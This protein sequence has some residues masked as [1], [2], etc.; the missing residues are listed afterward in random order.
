MQDV[1]Q[2]EQSPTGTAAL[3]TSVDEVLFDR[4]GMRV[5]T[6]SVVMHGRRW[7]LEHVCGVTVLFQRPTAR[8]M[9][10]FAV[11]AGAMVLV[12]LLVR[13]PLAAAH[14]SGSVGGGV[15]SVAA[16]AAYSVL[17]WRVLNAERVYIWLHTRFSSQMVYRGRSSTMTRALAHALRTAVRRK[18]MDD[19]H[20][21]AA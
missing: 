2:R 8:W 14:A 10:G 15:F 16:L 11:L 9:H 7:G 20:P 5:T 17:A 3:P 18:G 21:D 12:D 4:D 6:R 1:L 13:G 19:A